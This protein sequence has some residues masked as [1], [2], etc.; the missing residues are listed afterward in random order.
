MQ[1]AH[2]LLQKIFTANIKNNKGSCTYTQ[3]LNPDGGIEGD[4]TVV[5]LE[6]DYY[7]IISSA[8]TRERD[9]FHINKYLDNNKLNDV[10][11]KYC[12][13]NIWSKKQRS[14]VKIVFIKF[15]K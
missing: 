10:T 5:C 6:K 1:N 7:R 2:E 8:N 14:H 3:M 15:F 4:V 12:V 9:K 13:L 11:D